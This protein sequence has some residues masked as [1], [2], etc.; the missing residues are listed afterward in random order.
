[1]EKAPSDL[2]LLSDL[3][4]LGLV[5]SGS[6]GFLL[7]PNLLALLFSP[8]QASVGILSMTCWPQGKEE[9]P[10]RNRAS[11]VPQVTRK[12][13]TPQHSV[14]GTFLTPWLL[15]AGSRTGRWDPTWHSQ[16]P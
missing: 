11:L 13:Y 9:L 10:I 3:G 15:L 14:S 8:E 2:N 7:V 16:L 6:L 4:G 12:I 1:M 5:G